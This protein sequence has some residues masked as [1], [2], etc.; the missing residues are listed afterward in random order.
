MTRR[1]L[2]CADGDRDA[3]RRE[4]RHEVHRDR[5]ADRG[6]RRQTVRRASVDSRRRARRQ[7]AV[8]ARR[9]AEHRLVATG[10][11]LCSSSSVVHRRGS[12]SARSPS[13]RS[14]RG[15]RRAE[16]RLR[17]TGSP[18]FRPG[19]IEL[20]RAA[21]TP[22]AS[23]Q[24]RPSIDM[25]AAKLTV[26][27]GIARHDDPRQTL[28]DLPLLVGPWRLERT[29]DDAIAANEGAPSPN[30]MSDC[31]FYDGQLADQAYRRSAPSCSS[32]SKTAGPHP[33]A[34]WNRSCCGCSGVSRATRWSFVKHRSRGESHRPGRVDLL[35]PA[36]RLI[37]EA[38]G[39]RWHARFERLRP[40]PVARQRGRRPRSSG[41]A[42]HLGPPHRIGDRSHSTWST[43]R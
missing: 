6:T 2:N 18:G 5:P 13:C 4:R 37:I 35:L 1:L 10:A 43:A 42:L 40:R 27:E 28:F 26:I 24:L 33:R 3:T 16:R 7:R 22:T 17:S 23:T 20:R 25:P 36:H 31:A 39:R 34:S 11:G 38:D 9:L 29:I 32:D 15:D 14:S 41:P 30:S 12:A 8:R 19:R 21:R